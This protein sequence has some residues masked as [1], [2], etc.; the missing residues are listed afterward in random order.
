[1]YPEQM[2]APMRQDLTQEGVVELRTA[3]EVDQLLSTEKGTVLVVVNSVCGCAAANANC[4][5]SYDEYNFFAQD[6]NNG[7]GHSNPGDSRYCNNNSTYDNC[8]DFS[9]VYYIKVIR[10]DGDTDCTPYTLSVGN[11]Y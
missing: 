3:E 5:G 8:A 11:G 7:S 2:V 4:S 10:T 6:D 9:S 1:M